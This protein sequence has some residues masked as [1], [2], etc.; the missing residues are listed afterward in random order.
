MAE[1][2]EKEVIVNAALYCGDCMEF[3]KSVPDGAHALA[4]AEQSSLI[5]E[6]ERV[7]QVQEVLV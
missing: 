1:I 6:P 4:I 7:K 5:F 2:G 3:M